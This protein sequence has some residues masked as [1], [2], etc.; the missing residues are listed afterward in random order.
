MIYISSTP[1]RVWDALTSAEFSR[2]YFSGL[3]VETELT[4]G[5]AF[6]VRMPDGSIHISGEVIECDP[7]RKL[8]ITWN[9]N[10]P[11]LVEKLGVTLVTYEIEPAGDPVEPEEPAG[12]RR[13]PCRQD[14]AAAAD[15]GGAEEDGDRDTVAASLSSRVNVVDSLVVFQYRSIGNR[16]ASF[17]RHFDRL[18]WTDRYPCRTLCGRT[19]Y[20]I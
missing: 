20:L 3:A 13:G 1:E 12:D 4:T 15:A 9:V 18:P 6:V 11:D 17:G 10:R 2:K 16:A 7:P 14:G 8:T 5:G 19:K